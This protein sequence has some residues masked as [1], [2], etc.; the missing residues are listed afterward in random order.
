M[1]ALVSGAH[2]EADCAA[3]GWPLWLAEL[4]VWLFDAFDADYIERGRALAVAIAASDR[5]WE[6]VYRDVRLNAV[7]PI[8]LRSIGDGDEDWRV[9]C[10]RVVQ[11]SIDNDGEAAKAAGAAEAACAA[12]AAKAA[13][14]AKAAEAAE[15][16]WAARAAK[17]AGAAEAAWAAGAARAAKARDEIY[18]APM[19][20]LKSTT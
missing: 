3:K 1:S 13:G 5:D 12:R 4:T 7:L 18:D 19:A 20:S 10:R 14:A 6:R 9:E 15:A 16:V 17:A 2:S 8:A 11:W